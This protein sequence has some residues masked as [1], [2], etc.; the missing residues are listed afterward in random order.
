MK[1]KILGIVA[2]V[3]VLAAAVIASP[4]EHTEGE[5]KRVHQHIDWRQDT[6]CDCSGKELCSHL[7]L[8][9]IDTGGQEI[10]GKPTEEHDMF[11]EKAY[12]T[13]A[14]G[15]SFINVKVAVIDNEG[16]NNHINDEPDFTT[17][18]QI[19]VRGHESRHFEKSPYLLKFIDEKG[20]DNEISVMGM[21]AHHEWVLNG[22][23][24]DKSLVRNYMWYNISGELMEYAPNVRFCEV[25]LDGD[26]R[27]LYLMA[28][29]ITNGEECRL[30]L[31][32]N[33]KDSEMTG[34]LL[35]ADRP[36]EADLES[37]RDIYTYSE[38][39][40]LLKEDIAIRYPGK[41]KLTEEM[42]KDIELDYSAFEKALYSYDYDT[43]DYGYW[44]WIDV[45]NFVDYFLI[46][47]FTR[48]MDA[49]RYSTY[50]YKEPGEK[51]KL[52]V[53]DFNNACDNF[54]NDEISADGMTMA[55]SLWYLMLCKDEEFVEKIIERYE[56]LRKTYFS[57]EY[58]VEYIDSVLEYLGP[59]VERNSLRW[60]EVMTERE[61]LIPAGR[62]RHSQEEAVD[63]LKTWLKDRGAWLDENIDSLRAVAH[64]SRNR[65]FNH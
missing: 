8:V 55:E 45:D 47:E 59:A 2:V 11:G 40:M 44:N 38:R 35:R 43:E 37:T 48:N 27:G 57:E 7:P 65:A 10:P 12:T 61:P 3:I 56:S 28:E 32:I 53:W 29:S 58:L 63:Q 49:G 33:V 21:A 9:I 60:N 52:C 6:G 1:Y 31:N 23:Y 5:E 39:S 30:N 50:I 64:P 51:Y 46:N 18:A 19:R 26:Y 41:S 15:T 36:T 16:V 24:L 34:Y 14:D 17:T 13:V 62:N 25:I 42:A 22:P 20:E 54:I 4:V